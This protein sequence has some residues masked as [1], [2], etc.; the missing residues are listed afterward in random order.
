MTKL[1]RRCRISE[2]RAAKAAA[3]PSLA[4]SEA[5]NTAQKQMSVVNRLVPPLTLWVINRILTI[6]SV[7]EASKKVDVKAR[8][9]RKSA[10]SVLKT[11][12]RNAKRSRGSLAVGATAVAVGIGLIANAMRS[13]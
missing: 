6:P 8:R 4:T 1:M 9:Q 2:R 3:G 7:A 5:M 11:A 13:K 10:V 12:R